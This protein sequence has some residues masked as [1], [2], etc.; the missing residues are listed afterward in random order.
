MRWATSCGKQFALPMS[1]LDIIADLLDRLDARSITSS[2]GAARPLPPS[3]DIGPG[4]QSVGPACAILLSKVQS[5]DMWMRL[6][7]GCRFRQPRTCRRTRPGQLWAN[8]GSGN[9]SVSMASRG[10]C[11]PRLVRDHA[12]H[13]ASC[14]A[15]YASASFFSSSAVSFGCSTEMVSLLILPVN[16]NGI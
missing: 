5:V 1:A 8:A 10:R 15:R 12:D 11:G 2:L 7:C 3:E 16:V 9:A 13:F 4:G 14:A 6:G